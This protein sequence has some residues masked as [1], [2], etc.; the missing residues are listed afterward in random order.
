M[1]IKNKNLFVIY[2][3]FQDAYLHVCDIGEKYIADKKIVITGICR[4]VGHCLEKNIAELDSFAKYGPKINYFVYENDSTDDTKNILSKLGSNDRFKFISQD[5]S[6]P[7]FGSLKSLERTSNLA[8]HR[9]QCL[10]YIKQHHNNTDFVIVVDLDFNKISINGLLHSFGIFS[11]NYPFIDAIAGNSFQ[12]KKHESD[13]Q[14]NIW[15]YDCWAYRGNWWNDLY[16][17][18]EHNMFD[19]MLWFGLW[20]PL[21]GSLPAK[22]N[23]AFGGCCIYK[24]Q[25][26]ILGKYEGYDCEHVCFHKYLSKNHGLNLFLNPAQIMLFT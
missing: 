22:V 20:H 9:N 10:E 1:N 5:L 21:I 26:Y 13:G 18:P 19:P 24:T 23:S 6:L 12:I 3:E 17:Y 15:N 4:N 7:Q 25:K 11:Q 16:Q 14:Q 8:K 2:P